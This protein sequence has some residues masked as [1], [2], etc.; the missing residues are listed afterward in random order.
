[1]YA[2]MND[3]VSGIYVAAATSQLTTALAL[4][5]VAVVVGVALALLHD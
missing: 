1:M 5:L 2:D 3:I 4:A